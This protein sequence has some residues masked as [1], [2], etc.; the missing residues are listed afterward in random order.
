MEMK[1]TKVT[2]SQLT[3]LRPCLPAQP[4]WHYYT[5]DGHCVGPFDTERERE[6]DI[7]KHYVETRR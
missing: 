3:R 4:G 5:P 1:P 6:A 7:A 2:V